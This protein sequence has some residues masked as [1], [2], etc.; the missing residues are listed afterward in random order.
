MHRSSMQTTRSSLNTAVRTLAFA[1]TFAAS[2]LILNAG[3][4]PAQPPQPNSTQQ[5]CDELTRLNLPG[6]TVHSATLVPAGP[7][8][9]PNARPDAV[10]FNVPD[11]CRVIAV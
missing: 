1:S 3:P 7:F 9:L 8:R 6:I 2:S 4:K 5:H 11:F 10:P